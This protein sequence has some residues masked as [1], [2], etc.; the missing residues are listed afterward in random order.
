MTSNEKMVKTKFLN[1]EEIWNFVHTFFICSLGSKN[2]VWSWTFL[3]LKYS[4]DSDEK[5]TNNKVVVLK[6]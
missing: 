6:M 2:L 5:T 1:I 3:I 4:N